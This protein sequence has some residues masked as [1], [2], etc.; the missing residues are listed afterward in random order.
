MT[1]STKPEI[2]NVLH[3]SHCRREENR[4][5]ATLRLNPPTEG[6]PGTIS[7]KFSVDVMS[8]WQTAKKNC[9]KFQPAG[10]HQRYRQTTYGTAIA[11][12][13]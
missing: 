5:T 13:E 9:R 12:S 8:R 7:V 4:A 10:A 1:S 6:S 2:H 11:Y 3:T